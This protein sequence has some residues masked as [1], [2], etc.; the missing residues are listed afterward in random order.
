MAETETYSTEEKG[1]IRE[2]TRK[3]RRYD[4]RRWDPKPLDPSRQAWHKQKGESVQAYEAFMTYLTL[5][6]DERTI[7]KVSQIL[8]KSETLLSRWSSQWSW[9]IRVGSYEEHF[10]L[11]RLDSIEADRDDMFRQHRATTKSAVTIVEGELAKL[12]DLLN[13]ADDE[14]KKK[15][16]LEPK[17]LIRLLD[18]ATKADRETVMKRAEALAQSAEAHERLLERE[19]DEIASFVKGLMEE[20]GLDAEQQQVVKAYMERKLAA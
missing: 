18:V 19:A 12:L 7:R 16:A 14:E 9:Q 4:P 1:G 6:Q 5:P 2:S 20:L 17:D 10:L 15:L 11:M 13:E 3:T 8:S